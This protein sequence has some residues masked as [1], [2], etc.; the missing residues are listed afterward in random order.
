LDIEK[1]CP[2]KRIVTNRLGQNIITTLGGTNTLKEE[3]GHNDDD[4]DNDIDILEGV[5]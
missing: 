3:E 5:N 4:D 2:T 1:Q